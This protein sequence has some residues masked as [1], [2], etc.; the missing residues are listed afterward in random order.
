[1][2]AID[3]GHVI[4]ITS[5]IGAKNVR[6]NHDGNGMVRVA[7]HRGARVPGSGLLPTLEDA[8]L[9]MGLHRGDEII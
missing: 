4:R 7:E 1:M 9:G 5:G 3:E 6:L 2:Q 8:R